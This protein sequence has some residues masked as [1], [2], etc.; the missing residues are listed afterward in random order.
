MNQ[1]L[2]DLDAETMRHL[3]YQVVD[4]LAA[5]IAGLDDEPAWQGASRAELEARLRHP[6]PETAA[7]FKALLDRLIH[8]VLPYTARVDHPRFFGFVPGSATWPG[9][10]ADFLAAG[11]NVFQGTWLASSGPSEIELVVL[12]WFRTW[13][14]MPAEAGGLFT[15]GGSVATLTAIAAAR[16]LRLG[17]HDPRA[18]V[19]RSAE[20]HSSV[21][22][23]LLLLGFGDSQ[24]RVVACDDRQRIR[25]DALAAAM[26]ADTAAGR[27]PFLVIANAGATSTGAIDP[28]PELSRLCRDR[29]VWFHI[30]AAYGGFVILTERGRSWLAG[31]GEADSITLD[32]H[33]WLYQPFE[34]G[35]LMVRD[36]RALAAAFHLSPD[37]LRDAAVADNGPDAPSEVNF[38]DRGVQLTRSARALKIWLSIHYFG[39]DAFRRAIDRCLDLAVLAEDRIRGS[40]TLELVTPATLG[41]VSFRRRVGEP[42]APDAEGRSEAVNAALVRG[43]ARS[44]LG[45]ISSTRVSGRYVLRICIL[46]HRTRQE[47]VER[48]LDWLE[49]TP[50]DQAAHV[51]A[52]SR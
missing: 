45:M 35:C 4:H 34:A 20:C 46:N 11:H 30:D 24:V 39:L 43:L 7:T 12:D 42:D 10:L 38:T 16:R 22:R 13:L 40:A 8:D 32:P 26:D 5:R 19:Y 27:L 50:V 15:S 2:L 25:P 21:E 52:S 37:Y 1:P 17:G 28:I 36:A 6:A 3:G 31:I 49:T 47:D 23:A 44:G 9:V 33:K 29:G 18:I 51:L 48:V 41:I 14:G